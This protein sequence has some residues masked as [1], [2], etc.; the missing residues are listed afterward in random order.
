M[1]KKREHLVILPN[2]SKLN[3]PIHRTIEEKK[4]IVEDVIQEWEDVLRKTWSNQTAKLT[5]DMLSSYLI[6]HDDEVAEGSKSY[7]K[8]KDFLSDYRIK[9]METGIGN[10]KVSP[11]SSLGVKDAMWYHETK[12]EDERI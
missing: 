4:L 11:A 5:L 2:G 8:S 3:L 12:E 10:N 7:K 9:E 6:F 1:N